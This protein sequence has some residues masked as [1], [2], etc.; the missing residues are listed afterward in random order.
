MSP[1]PPNTGYGGA[2]REVTKLWKSTSSQIQNGGRWSTFRS[3]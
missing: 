2:P 3:L 1:L